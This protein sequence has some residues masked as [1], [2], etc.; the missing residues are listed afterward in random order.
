[1]NNMQSLQIQIRKY[2]PTTFK[3]VVVCDG[4]FHR[5]S[6]HSPEYE[7]L[8]KLYRLDAMIDTREWDKNIE[9]RIPGY[10]EESVDVQDI[11]NSC[12]LEL[13]LLFLQRRQMEKMDEVPLSEKRKDQE[14][15]QCNELS[16]D[17]HQNKDDE[18]FE[19]QASELDE[20]F[21]NNFSQYANEYL[22]VKLKFD[23]ICRYIDFGIYSLRKEAKTRKEFA[24]KAEQHRYK[25]MIFM[26]QRR[27]ID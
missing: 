17:S 6:Y 19:F 10:G 27:K 18:E 25:S 15:K 21:V 13:I 22:D 9:I 20:E 4:N 16:I 2:S 11:R 7:Q 5:L 8:E 24:E 14:K 26:L 1:M 3:G 12:F 23:A